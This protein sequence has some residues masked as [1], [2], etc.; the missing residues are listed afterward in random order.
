VP[1]TVRGLLF[2]DARQFLAQLAGVCANALAVF[3]LAFGFFFLLERTFGNR[4]S[5][6][7]ELSGLD[8][9]EMGSDAYPPG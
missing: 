6:E 3:A 1:G 9:L 7:T 4:V 8:A 2:G 5:A